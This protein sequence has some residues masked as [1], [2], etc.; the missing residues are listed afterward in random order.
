MKKIF[1][2]TKEQ[3]TFIPYGIGAGVG[4]LV[5]IVLKKFVDG[6]STYPSI[7]QKPSIYIP[8]VTGIGAIFIGSYT[9]MIKKENTKKSLILYGITASLAGILSAIYGTSLTAGLAQAS[10]CP[11]CAQKAQYQVARNQGGH[12]QNT[13]IETLPSRFSPDY[14]TNTYYPFFQ[15][16]FLNRPQTMARGWGS[17]VTRNPMAA[18][19]TTI[20]RTVIRS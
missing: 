6:N 17:D 8:I 20:P 1:Q 14:Y 18:I 10:S 12:T 11:S 2:L 7:W 9:K 3:K 4:V 15:G 16:N 13:M 5:P 19:P